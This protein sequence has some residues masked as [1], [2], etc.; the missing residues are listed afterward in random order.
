MA[1]WSRFGQFR[2]VRHG[3]RARR[4]ASRHPQNHQGRRICWYPP[5]PHSFR[6]VSVFIFG[7]IGLAILEVF[8]LPSGAARRNREAYRSTHYIFCV[9]AIQMCG[10]SQVPLYR[11]RCWPLYA[12]GLSRADR[13]FVQHAGQ[14]SGLSPRWRSKAHILPKVC[15]LRD[16]VGIGSKPHSDRTKYVAWVG[17]LIP[18]K[19][20]DILIDIARSAPRHPLSCLRRAIAELWRA[21]CPRTA[22]DAKYR[23]PRTSPA[24]KSPANYRR[25][26]VLLCTSD[27]EGFPNTF[28]QAWSNGT[29]VVSL[30]I[31]PDRIIE[32][33]GLGALSVNADRAITD[34][35]AP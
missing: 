28:I 6:L 33:M 32:R 9:L 20:P 25:A 14:L 1:S 29:P 30:K 3:G 19:R 8:R 4:D 15:I 34:I 26:A 24:R 11:P 21:D 22:Q 31:D 17:T 7:T 16:V 10:Q 23:I 5:G 35:T 2:L 13:I 12:W 27:V 18:E